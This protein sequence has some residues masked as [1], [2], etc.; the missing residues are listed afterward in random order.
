MIKFEDIE[1]PDLEIEQDYGWVGIEAEMERT[2]KGRPVVNEQN[3]DGQPIDLFGGSDWAW[4]TKAILKNLTALAN[5]VNA[6]YTL[7][8]EGT[9]YRVRW[10]H[11][12]PPVIE[13]T[14]IIGRPN[15][16]DSDYYSNIKLKFMEV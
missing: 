14:P 6:V 3:I 12:E 1:L 4:V 2:I 7:S 10:R 15:S 13:A 9:I 16:E 5:I 11:E 8:Y